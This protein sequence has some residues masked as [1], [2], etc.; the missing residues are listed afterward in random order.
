MSVKTISILK[1][2]ILQAVV[3]GD[4]QEN[5]LNPEDSIDAV[6]CDV[7]TLYIRYTSKYT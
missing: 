1:H 6:D 3:G 7:S 2:Y 5:K 4:D